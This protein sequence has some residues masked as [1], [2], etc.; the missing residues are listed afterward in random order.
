[1]PTLI[2]PYPPQTEWQLL[3]AEEFLHRLQPGERGDLVDGESY[4]HSPVSLRHARLTN[5]LERLLA[6]HVEQHR[7]G[8]VHRESVAVRLQSRHVFMPDIAFFAN[9]QVAQFSANYITVAPVFVAEILSPA[10]A[11]LDVGPK[12]V[13]YEENGV[14]EYWVLDQGEALLHRFY[15]REGDILVEFAQTGDW[16][17]SAAV[18][19]FK[20]QR[21]WLNPDHAP[22]VAEC[23]AAMGGGA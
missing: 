11:H 10:T 17:E 12:F 4:M 3:T 20:V 22:P 5:F 23:L 2:S 7:L 13:A 21:A 14:R 19:G 1:M 15:R 18:P 9:A 8:Q 6:A 16:I